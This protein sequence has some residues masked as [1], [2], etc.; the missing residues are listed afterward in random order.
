VI[1]IFEGTEP[2]LA[3]VQ[4]AVGGWVELVN[5]PNGDQMLVDEDGLSKRLPLNRDAS[6]MAGKPIVGSVAILRG[7]AKWR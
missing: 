5:L 3:E 2:T 6:M 7:G 1:T 4:Q